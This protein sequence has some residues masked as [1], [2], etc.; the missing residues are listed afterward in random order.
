MQRQFDI[1]TKKQWKISLV[2]IVMA[3]SLVIGLIPSLP[4]VQLFANQ[5]AT[6]IDATL[7]VWED[8]DSAQVVRDENNN[9]VVRLGDDG[10][11]GNIFHE[12]YEGPRTLVLSGSAKVDAADDEPAIIGLNVYDADYVLFDKHELEI[13]SV[14]EYQSDEL[15]IVLPEGVLQLQAYVYKNPGSYHAYIDDVRLTCKQC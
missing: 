11:L 9:H 1:N 10:G 13:H 3:V 5:D 7:D 8:W 6:I 4:L 2:S 14:G 15:E 12:E